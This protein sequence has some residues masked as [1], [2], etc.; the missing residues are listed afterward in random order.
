MNVVE[1]KHS[2]RLPF[3]LVSLSVGQMWVAVSVEHTARSDGLHPAIYRKVSQLRKRPMVPLE[4]TI[5]HPL[6]LPA[7][8][9]LV[10]M[11]AGSSA[12]S[13]TPRR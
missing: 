6:T 13:G 1:G 4:E 10:Y 7:P 11:A 9:E 3:F 12:N 5:L 2:V 8:C